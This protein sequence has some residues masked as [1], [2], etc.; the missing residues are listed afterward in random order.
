MLGLIFCPEVKN[1]KWIFCATRCIRRSIHR[2]GIK[3]MIYTV[4]CFCLD[5]EKTCQ[6]IG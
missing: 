5:I 1:K 2:K 3:V 6:Q 4:R